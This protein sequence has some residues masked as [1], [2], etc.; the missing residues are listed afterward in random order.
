M[1][2]RKVAE[3]FIFALIGALIIPM[4]TMWLS[5]SIATA[6][7]DAY[8]IP[9][10]VTVIV[11]SIVLPFVMKGILSLFMTISMTHVAVA[12]AIFVIQIPVCGLFFLLGGLPL[13]LAVSV[14]AGSFMSLAI[15]IIL[16]PFTLAAEIGKGIVK[17][18]KGGDSEKKD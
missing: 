18:I 9:A 13:Y 2:A 3:T 12:L 10:I 14:L 6:V 15:T 11:A 8:S 5:G 7:E 1:L 16:R 4:V 17:G